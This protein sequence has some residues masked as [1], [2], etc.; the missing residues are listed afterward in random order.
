MTSITE[1]AAASPT[2]TL[3]YSA[4][5]TYDVYGQA[6]QQS[7]WTASAGTVVTRF[8]N[9]GN[10][11]GEVWAD[12]TSGNALSVRY[13]RP[14]GTNALGARISSSGTVAWY[15]TDF[16]GSV[17][18]LTD[19]SGVVQ[20]QNTYDAFGNIVNQTNPS[21]SDRFLYAGEPTNI[22]AKL[23]DNDARWYNTAT[24]NWMRQDPDGLSPDSDPY[25]YAAN[26]PTNA[27]DP[28]GQ[29]LLADSKGAADNLITA[30][31]GA[32]ISV[33][34][35]NVGGA[36]YLIQYVSGNTGPDSKNPLIVST[37]TAPHSA[38]D[39]TVIVD[40]A[41]QVR[42]VNFISLPP[43]LSNNILAAGLPKNGPPS[44]AEAPGTLGSPR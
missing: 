20:N 8:A 31:A 16:Q 14:D 24:G 26:S 23:S 17:M 21:F 32:N 37:N 22:T 11:N 38:S 39:P 27:T 5:Y 2:A 4:T 12:L 33:K 43:I 28:S 36:N 40:A 19:N 9:D 3:T 34:S 13:V 30:Y 18:A 41:D 29:Y 44:Q 42:T 1:R 15:L 35:T 7:V 25:R 6:I 10:D